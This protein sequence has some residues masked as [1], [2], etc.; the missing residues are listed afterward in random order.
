MAAGHA[1]STFVPLSPA[2]TDWYKLA[3]R[4]AIEL[5]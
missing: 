1:T 3:H 5:V 4:T 2:Q